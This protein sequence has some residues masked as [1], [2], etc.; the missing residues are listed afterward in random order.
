MKKIQLTRGLQALVSSE[1]YEY[2]KMYNW[3]AAKYPGVSYAVRGLK[4]QGKTARI[5]MHKEI[6]AHMSGG[7][8]SG[9]V[10]HL[11]GDGLDNRRENLVLLAEGVGIRREKCISRLKR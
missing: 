3:F 5:Y 1:D 8:F 9:R 6:A 4:R 10:A 2:L 7:K 11:N